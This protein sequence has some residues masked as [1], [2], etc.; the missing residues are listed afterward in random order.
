MS[1]DS[2]IEML[3]K[4]L[5]ALRKAKNES[6]FSD[7]ENGFEIIIYKEDYDTDDVLGKFK[8]FKELKDFWES[9]GK[10]KDT[11]KIYLEIFINQKYEIYEASIT[12]GIINENEFEDIVKVIS[13]LDAWHLITMTLA[14]CNKND[15]FRL[16]T[17]IKSEKLNEFEELHNASMTI[18][19]SQMS[20]DEYWK[21]ID[22]G[23]K[24]K[25]FER[26]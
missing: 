24:F 12:N 14:V 2:E 8:T 11:D 16:M 9:N 20:E 21:K 1:I 26:A 17:F 7:K 6:K 5:S 3:E 19:K 4:R 18:I 13:T 22:E 10:L 23:K 25:L 15:I